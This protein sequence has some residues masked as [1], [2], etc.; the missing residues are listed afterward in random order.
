VKLCPCGSTIDYLAC[1]GQYHQHQ[2]LPK[3]P[4]ALMRS[5]YT[6]YTLANINY[7]KQTMQGKPLLGFNEQEAARWSKSVLW[8][9]LQV[10]DASQK[11]EKNGEVEFIATYLEGQLVKTIHEKS[12]FKVTAEHWFYIDGKLFAEPN[13]KISL[14]NTCP[15]GSGKKFKNC[16]GKVE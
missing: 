15:C 7:I 10:L 11:D 3:T 6:A 8:L 9:G 12:Q 5:R 4:E 1:C 16:H 2:T 14:N 13:R